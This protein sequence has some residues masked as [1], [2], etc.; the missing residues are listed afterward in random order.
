MIDW[1]QVKTAVEKEVERIESLKSSIVSATQ[2]RLDEFAKTRG[3]DGIL[4]AA[5]YATSSNTTFAAEGQYCVTSRD[6]TWAALYT[7]M[8]E[9]EA[10]T[11][12]MPNSFVDVE[13]GLPLLV[14]P[15]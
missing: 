14:W 15:V 10:G 12:P 11:R 7:I 6:E 5:T 3:Y 9:V 13:P 4:S 1:T 8:S 2:S